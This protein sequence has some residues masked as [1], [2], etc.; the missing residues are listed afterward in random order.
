MKISRILAAFKAWS[1]FRLMVVIGAGLTVLSLLAGAFY[2][3][4]AMSGPQEEAERGVS[5]AGRNLPDTRAS[6]SASEEPPA[7]APTAP[8]PTPPLARAVEPPPAPERGQSFTIFCSTIEPVTAGTSPETTECR[9]RSYEGFSGRVQLS[10]PSPPQQLRCEFRP[11]TVVLPANGN[12][13]SQM[14]VIAP[15]L[16]PDNYNLEVAGQGGGRTSTATFPLSVI[17]P[18]VAAPPAPAPQPAAV[19]TTPPP[20]P[21]APTPSPE[22]TFTIACSVAQPPEEPI[23]RLLW[24]LT[25]GPKGAIK[26][27]VTPKNGFNEE[28]TLTL[29]EAP[30][31][32]QH[33]FNPQVLSLVGG[34]TRSFD[35]NFDLGELEQGKEYELEVTGTSATK[36]VVKQVLLTVTQ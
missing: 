3:Q 26:C 28:V 18:I 34:A 19:A 17:Q 33:T 31:V 25:Q 22:A 24:S 13:V 15:N 5:S 32:L 12:A 2:I 11:S 20:P 7:E 29:S 35:L 36:T 16:R 9:V 30:D 14:T 6:R 10:C 4:T 1:N 21:P 27:L 8:T 23:D